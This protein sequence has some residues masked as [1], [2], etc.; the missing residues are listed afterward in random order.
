MPY[1][2][3]LIVESLAQAQPTT[4]EEKAAQER[5]SAWIK[6]E[7]SVSSVFVGSGGNG[8]WTSNLPDLIPLEYS[9]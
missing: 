7:N 4:R 1:I 2:S 5:A 9:A 8:M 6:V 3:L